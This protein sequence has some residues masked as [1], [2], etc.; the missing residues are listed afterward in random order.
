[1]RI[2]V[3]LFATL[4][5]LLPADRRPQGSLDVPAGSRVADVPALLGMTEGV[6]HMIL[7]NGEDVPGEHVLTEGDALDLFP[8]LAGGSVSRRR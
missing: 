6:P 8:P 1:M 4:A 7:V 3:R 5:G 2:E